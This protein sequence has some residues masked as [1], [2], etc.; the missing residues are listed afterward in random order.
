M[1]SCPAG[2]N[3]Q[4]NK[5]KLISRSITIKDYMRAENIRIAL[6]HILRA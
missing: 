3:A 1:G 2:K 5:N 4:H 6:R